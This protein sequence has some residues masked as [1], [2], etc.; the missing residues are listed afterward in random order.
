MKSPVPLFRPFCFSLLFVCSVGAQQPARLEALREA[1]EARK[2]VEEKIK[3]SEVIVR[4][5]AE[6]MANNAANYS[7]NTVPTLPLFKT[8][9]ELPGQQKKL[10]AVA[11]EERQKHEAFL[12]QPD[13]GLFKLLTI[14]ETRLAIND[15]KAQN[16]VPQLIGLGAFFSFTKQTHNADEWAQI[17][18]KNGVFLPA[19]LEMKRNTLASSGGMAQSFVY[20]SGYSLAL[21]TMLGNMALDDLA[22]PHPA[23]QFLVAWQPPTQYQDF[24]SQAKQL[25]T[26]VN[27]GQQRFQSSIPARPETT[28][29][30]RAINYK[31]ADVIVAFRIVQQDADGS[32]HIL[33][34]QLQSV[35]PIELKGKP[36]KP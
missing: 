8:E 23:L 9:N 31:K 25:Q 34:K 24:I 15:V 16:S 20:T 12:R 27:L 35:P 21:F 14:D 30:M 28:Y 18:L 1:E 6:S 26:G 17:R 32:L 36:A 4:Q 13:T 19:Y 29:A 5:R 33:W 10:L 3:E 2:K 11:P 7:A 22:L